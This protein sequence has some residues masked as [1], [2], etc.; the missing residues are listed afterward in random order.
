MIVR[1]GTVAAG[2]DAG[3]GV[4]ALPD[5]L[6]PVDMAIGMVS[7]GM[8]LIPGGTFLM[9]AQASD[10]QMPGYDPQAGSNEGPPHQVALSAFYLDA[11][12]NGGVIPSE[13]DSR[14]REVGRR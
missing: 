13:N 2:C 9:G 4:A 10:D 11:T 3:G 6:T 8:M 14:P 1:C 7:A 12:V 5:A